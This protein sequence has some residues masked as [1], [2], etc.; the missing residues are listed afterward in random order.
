[1]HA[2]WPPW[3]SFLKNNVLFPVEH[4]LFSIG[5]TY[6]SLIGSFLSGLLVV[7]L[8]PGDSLL[9]DDATFV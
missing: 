4:G 5:C 3:N 9:T 6:V 8:R 1:M 7:M 2:T